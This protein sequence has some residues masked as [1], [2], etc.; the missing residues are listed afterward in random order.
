MST[1]TPTKQRRHVLP[2]DE[3]SSN[4][5]PAPPQMHEEFNA[6]ILTTP[7]RRGRPKTP[8]RST[9][10]TPP[11]RRRRAMEN[12]DDANSS[13]EPLGIREQQRMNVI[14]STMAHDDDSEEAARPPRNGRQ[15]IFDDDVIDPL[16]EALGPGA[17][18]FHRTDDPIDNDDPPDENPHF[19]LGRLNIECP[20]CGALHFSCEVPRKR[21][22]VATFHDCCPGFKHDPYS[23]TEFPV[24]LKEL[25]NH[26][27]PLS[28]NFFTNIRQ[29][30]QAFACGSF[31][32]PSALNDPLD[33][34]VRGDVHRNIGPIFPQQDGHAR[35]GQVYI[36]DT[37][38]GIRHR[39]NEISN[40]DLDASLLTEL[41][42]WFHLHN[43]YAQSYKMMLQVYEEEK[44][45]A[46]REGRQ[47]KQIALVFE[48]TDK[49]R[50]YNAPVSNEVAAVFVSDSGEP[51]P[52]RLF[53]FPHM[54]TL[55][56]ISPYEPSCDPLTYPLFFPN[57][58]SISIPHQSAGLRR[59]LSIDD[60]E[61]A[62][63]S[64]NDGSSSTS[65]TTKHPTLR[66]RFINILAIRRQWSPIHLG[67]KLLQQLIVDAFCRI[68]GA[69][70]DYL[71][72]H[73]TEL[74]GGTLKSIQDAIQENDTTDQIGRR[75]FLP[76][77][78]VGSPRWQQQQYMDAMS[79]VATT[80]KPDI[81][82]TFTC[83]R[84]WPEITENLGADHL[85]P[86]DRPDLIARVF[87]A[88]MDDL[89]KV[90]HQGQP[91]GQIAS[92]VLKVEF[93]KRGLPH[94]HILLTLCDRFKP[95][96]AERVDEIVKAEIPSEEEDPELRAQVLSLMVHTPCGV[97]NP[98][99][100]CM[101][102]GSCKKHFPKPLCTATS[103]KPDGKFAY[104]RS[105]SDN[106]NEDEIGN[107]WVVPYNPFLL[108][109]YNAH[110]NVEICSSVLAVKYLYKYIYKGADRAVLRV[111][112]SQD[113][114]PST[115][116]GT[117]QEDHPHSADEIQ[118]YI[119]ARYIGSPEAAWRL[120]AFPMQ[121]KS[122]TIVRL[123]VHLEGTQTIFFTEG[124]ARRAIE[125]REQKDTTL[126]AFFKL[127]QQAADSPHL[128]DEDAVD[129]RTLTYDQIPSAFTWDLTTHSWKR[130][131][132][133][134][135]KVI[136]RMYT[137]SPRDRERYFLR[138]ILLRR[139]GP[140]SFAD[141]RVVDTIQHNTFESA[142]RALGL[143]QDDNQWILC[144]EEAV[145]IALP[146][147]LRTIFAQILLFNNPT[148]VQ[149]L[150][151]TFFDQL[152]V[153][154]TPTMSEETKHFRFV[155]LYIAIEH[156]LRRGGME[157]SSLIPPPSREDRFENMTMVDQ[158][159]DHNSIAQLMIQSLNNEQS[160]AFEAIIS[161]A[162]QPTH[163]SK[164]FFLDGPGGSGKTFLYQAVYH[165][166]KSLGKNV[167][168]VAFTGIA[169]TLLPHGRT[170]HSTFKLPVP[171]DASNSMSRLERH[172]EQADEVRSIDVVIWDE[173][174]MASRFALE[175]VNSI[176]Q[177]L[178]RNDLPFGGIVIRAF[179]KYP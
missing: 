152:T 3:S 145:R 137:V 46:R 20:I 158:D 172:S 101:E 4:D 125:D 23:R 95:R 143:L 102:D 90:L 123:A 59:P 88:K 14:R 179:Q 9:Y 30:N 96:T 83:N 146:Q 161:A 99:A 74:F 151:D 55:M 136:A 134:S 109:R 22:G 126:I 24:I 173:A 5:S 70:L 82:L 77:S 117:S 108:R 71:R 97:R 80:G 15:I 164:C 48:G 160:G 52:Q 31:S 156:L 147:Q 72:Q 85:H 39:I 11:I 155:K 170:L 154:F 141:L 79:I 178:H 73:Q 41:S 27:H 107:E 81:F 128:Q 26:S 133:S 29:F 112:E 122:H 176:L 103:V 118:S 167:Q 150:W 115:E 35:F 62:A 2:D 111:E 38:E 1:N 104:R 53:I 135:R 124:G 91:F 92:Y 60:Q 68:E 86:Q 87:K 64:E 12:D 120:L 7:R 132:R 130:R 169:A 18:G 116:M 100:V 56:S 58:E 36:L 148:N 17:F 121:K 33:I 6:S 63:E 42:E 162:T 94:C 140:T 51:P 89:L 49:R 171:L 105:P 119:Q 84:N 157:L 138:L 45:A 131:K 50:E 177:D 69:K 110:I 34:I 163:D 43:P 16:E 159:V 153:D 113:T 78:I 175:A 13:H 142:A 21:Q 8:S 44:E 144:M 174:P 75:V 168:C 37:G 166:L 57:G 61:E 40:E 76:S 114:L 47:M 93:Q 65:T 165:H 127:N 67:G 32:C 139:R 10:R 66:D 25:F 106:S 129:P 19:T 149:A 28:D 98:S 54:N